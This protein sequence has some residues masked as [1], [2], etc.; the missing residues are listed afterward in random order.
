MM[1]A[2]ALNRSIAGTGCA[3][4]SQIACPRQQVAGELLYGARLRCPAWSRVPRPYDERVDVPVRLG[5]WQ[6]YN[7]TYD[8]I[9]A[10]SIDGISQMPANVSLAI[11][12]APAHR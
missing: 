2:R 1:L 8:L 11:A 4:F 12:S 3:T 10:I 6:L 7:V 5:V 9:D